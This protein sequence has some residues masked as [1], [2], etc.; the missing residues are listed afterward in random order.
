MITH[1]SGMHS[2]RAKHA[3]M[4]FRFFSLVTLWIGCY[5]GILSWSPVPWSYIFHVILTHCALLAYPLAP[6]NLFS[7][8]E[9]IRWGFKSNPVHQDFPAIISFTSDP[10]AKEY[11]SQQQRVLQTAIRPNLPYSSESVMTFCPA[12][13]LPYLSPIST[14]FPLGWEGTIHLEPLQPQINETEL[15]AFCD[16]MVLSLLKSPAPLLPLFHLLLRRTHNFSVAWKGNFHIHHSSCG[17]V[18]EEYF[19]HSTSRHKKTH[20]TTHSDYTVHAI[21]SL[22]LS[23]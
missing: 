22:C 18:G 4:R 15:K 10:E 14:S 3:E 19:S 21:A 6:E 23:A 12:V 20:L 13:V 17:I 11:F 2:F 5:D 9:C 8:M 7:S 1:W 16:L